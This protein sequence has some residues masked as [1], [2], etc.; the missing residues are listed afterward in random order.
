MA[1][2]QVFELDRE[3]TVIAIKW[4]VKMRY[5][6]DLSVVRFP[7]G[8]KETFVKGEIFYLEG[9]REFPLDEISEKIIKSETH[10]YEIISEENE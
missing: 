10:G 9:I 2:R 6:L 3:E 4:Y 1:V 7:S 8:L 5:G